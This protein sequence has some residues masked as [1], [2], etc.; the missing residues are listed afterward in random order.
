MDY[1]KKKTVYLVRHGLVDITY[2]GKFTGSTDIRLCEKGRKQAFS[3]TKKI[4]VIK[5]DLCFSSPLHRV[6]ETAQRAMASCGTE[7]QYDNDLREIDFGQWEGKT[8]DEIER[9]YPQEVTKWSQFPPEF[10]FPDGESFKAFLDRIK[11]FASRVERAAG[12]SM[13][14]FTHGG[15]IRSLICYW[16]DLAP[17]NYIVFD[18]RPAS[19]TMIELYGNKGLLAGLDNT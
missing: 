8:F 5:P 15:V 10:S 7:I 6:K 3:L 11:R 19:I 1:Q 18:I 2:H 14:V 4:H 9:L 17:R 13:L 16:L 12:N